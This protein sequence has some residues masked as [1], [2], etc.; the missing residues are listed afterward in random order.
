MSNIKLHIELIHN[1]DKYLYFIKSLN[2]KKLKLIIYFVKYDNFYEEEKKDF[3]SNIDF[4]KYYDIVHLFLKFSLNNLN[5]NECERLIEETKEF[6]NR[7]YKY[8][9]FESFS[10]KYFYKNGITS[11]FKLNGVNMDMFF[12]IIKDYSKGIKLTLSIN[13]LKEYETKLIDYFNSILNNFN[14]LIINVRFFESDESNLSIIKDNNEINLDFIPNNISIMFPNIEFFEISDFVFIPNDFLK[15]MNKFKYLNELKIMGWNIQSINIVDNT[16]IKKLEILID[17]IFEFQS[18][19]K[20][21]IEIISFNKNIEILIISTSNSQTNFDILKNKCAIYRKSIYYLE[22]S[23]KGHIFGGFNEKG[24]LNLN[25]DI[26][27]L[28]N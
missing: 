25:F 3:I 27:I 7:V 10:L 19:I 28:F 5:V 21:I 17:E 6:E 4:E 1:I 8:D 9:E 14:K 18:I 24:Q 16:T 2:L 13:I 22:L 15:N 23:D 26:N 20:N 11:K 12:G